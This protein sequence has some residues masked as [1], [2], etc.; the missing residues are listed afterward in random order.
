MSQ[1]TSSM[2]AHSAGLAAL[3]TKAD[4]VVTAG[5]GGRQ[6]RIMLESHVKVPYSNMFQTV[7]DLMRQA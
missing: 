6:G 2:A 5:Y 1:V 3:D 7:K 4:L